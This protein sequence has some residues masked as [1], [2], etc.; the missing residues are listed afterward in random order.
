MVVPRAGAKTMHTCKDVIELLTEYMEGDLSP[1]RARALE[2]HLELC[3]ACKGF[4]ATL[5][6]TRSAVRD[7]RC[8][9]LPEDCH[10][11][12]RSFLDEGLKTRKA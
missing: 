8:Q 3:S 6:T 12:L 9:D 11:Q 10:R 7:L 4:L 1:D 5:G 2:A